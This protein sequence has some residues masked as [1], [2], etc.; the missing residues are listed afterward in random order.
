MKK[1]LKNNS[2]PENKKSRL[3]GSKTANQGAKKFENNLPEVAKRNNIRVSSPYGYYPEDVDNVI[4]ELENN[5]KLTQ[6]E[7]DHLTNMLKSTREELEDAKTE[8]TKLKMQISMIDI[9]PPDIIIDDDV[10]KNK[11]ILKPP[12]KKLTDDLL[13]VGDLGN[14]ITEAKKP[15]VINIKINKKG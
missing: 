10:P 11:K 13:I 4:I 7:N 12:K 6:K 9:A 5:L 8:L 2:P 3:F 1:D 14:S 15:A